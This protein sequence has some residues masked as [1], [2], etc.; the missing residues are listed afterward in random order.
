[1]TVVVYGASGWTGRKVART[2]QEQG[3]AVALAGRSRGRLEGI[4]AELPRAAA[5]HEVS[6]H[7]RRA[8]RGV[9]GGAELVVNCSGPFVETGMPI[10]RA[11][12]EAGIHY[13]DVSGEESHVREV[14]ASSHREAS[15]R[16]V[17][18]CPAFAPKGALGEWCARAMVTQPMRDRGVDEVHV[19]YAHGLRE[20]FRPSVASVLSSTGQGLFRGGQSREEVLAP[21]EFPFPPPFGRGL[22]LCVPSAEDCSIPRA[23]PKAR[24]RTY[25]SLHPGLPINELWA[26]WTH[27]ALPALPAFCQILFSS[28]GRVHLKLYLPKPE[29]FHDEETF[30]VSV[31]VRAGGE[32]VRIAAV[33]WDAYAVT[34]EIVALGVHRLL[35]SGTARGVVSPSELCPPDA[36]LAA[37]KS[38]GAIRLLRPR[39]GWS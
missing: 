6:M 30:A 31:E 34:A 12:L 18:V 32:V 39:Q 9:L 8:L 10:L 26:R 38:T 35:E 24:V 4:A 14:Y 3:I 7:D 33:A 21:R 25:I 37:L 13:M 2:L 20:Y 1:M 19:A 36:A 23:F 16:G 15:R 29:A 22:A 11:A 5:I 27:A 28:W 17:S